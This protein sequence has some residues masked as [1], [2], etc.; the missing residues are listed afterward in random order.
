MMRI[1]KEG[2]LVPEPESQIGLQALW[3]HALARVQKEMLP[4]LPPRIYIKNPQ[5]AVAGI[6][7][8]FVSGAY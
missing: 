3:G 6:L 7:Y 4:Q 8:A 2:R 1:K 5:P